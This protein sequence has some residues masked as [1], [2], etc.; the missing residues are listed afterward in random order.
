MIP[1]RTNNQGG[2][3]VIELLIAVVIIGV[4]ASVAI[5][6]YRQY[7]IESRRAEAQGFMAELALRQ[8]RWRANNP[9]YG[10]TTDISA[11]VDTLNF[12][13]FDVQNASGTTYT[14]RG[15]PQGTQLATDGGCNPLTL[16]ESGARG[17]AGCWKN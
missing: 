17:P 10:S 6:A 5:P 7:V 13:N 14:I 3:T 2:F 12:Y 16:T 4:L 11:G 9:S 15:I 8:E 1:I